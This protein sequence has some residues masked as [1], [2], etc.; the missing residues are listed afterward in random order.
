MILR[1]R[2]SKKK[3]EIVFISRFDYFINDIMDFARIQL[4]VPVSKES[5]RDSHWS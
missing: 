5:G 2:F 1:V 4:F 3:R